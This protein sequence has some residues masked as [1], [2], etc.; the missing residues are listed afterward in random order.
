MRLLLLPVIV[1]V[2]TTLSGCFFND[3]LVHGPFLLGASD[4]NRVGCCRVG[5]V[6]SDQA[7][8]DWMSGCEKTP[9][10]PGS[11]DGEGW[12]NV[13]SVATA[14]PVVTTALPPATPRRSAWD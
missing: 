3:P 9:C 1:L 8:S 5:D 13:N 14:V 11:L 6:R 12:N 7:H 2:G 10:P 4:S